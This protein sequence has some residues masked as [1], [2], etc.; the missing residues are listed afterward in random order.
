MRA[1][2]AKLDDSL[3]SGVI[4]DDW[5]DSHLTPVPKPNKDHSR[6][7]AYR[8]IT[9]Q[10]TVRKLLEKIVARRLATEL[11]EKNILKGYMD[12]CCHT[13]I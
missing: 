6:I 10:N 12:E 8:I 3:D 2:A 11:E 9:M 4:P 7:A 13:C 1:L 5:L